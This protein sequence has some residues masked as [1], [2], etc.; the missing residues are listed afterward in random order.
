MT[1]SVV[2][3]MTSAIAVYLGAFTYAPRGSPVDAP[4]GFVL[5]SNGFAEEF[6]ANQA[7]L[8][9]STTSPQIPPAI[10]TFNEAVE[11]F[12]SVKGIADGL[13]PIFNA[14]S[15]AECHAVPIPGGSSQITEKHAGRF[16]GITFFAHPGGT[17]IHDRA[18]HPSIQEHT[19][20]AQTNVTSIRST[21][22]LLG[23]GFVEAIANGTLQEIANGQPASMR[24]LV[25][26]VPV[27]EASEGQRSGRFGW[28]NQHGSLVSFA[29]ETYRNSMGITSPLAPQEPGTN[30]RVVSFDSVP[31]G[32]PAAPD[33]DGVDIEM[34]ALF[35]RSTLAPP[36]DPVRQATPDAQAGS[37]LF[38]NIGCAH[39]HTPS[40]VTSAPGLLING[41]A[42]TVSMA[43]GNKRIRP[44]GDFLLHDIGTGDGIVENGG[45]ATR[46]QIRTAP[47]W[48]V[49]ARGRLMHDGLSFDLN[50]AIQRHGNQASQARANFNGL[51]SKNRDRVLA[52]LLSL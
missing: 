28:K 34:F 20:P 16:D 29:A 9:H 40:I 49:R 3:G 48:G 33:S 25:I 43:L 50:D 15:C 8:S 2:F 42:L 30:R 14:A 6:C 1:R 13:G 10:C 39:C 4:T 52:F 23:A 26:D 24:G 37:A 5:A 41:G 27:L 44:Y 18:I 12:T 38:T 19:L 46:N 21:L 22:S 47:L 7:A 32:D 31:P 35:M 51:S 11:R 36:V 17:L 45:Q